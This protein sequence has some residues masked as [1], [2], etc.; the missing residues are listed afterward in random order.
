MW[1]NPTALHSDGTF[2]RLSARGPPHLNDVEDNIL[3]EAVQDTLGYAVV[4]PGSMDKQQILQ[5]FELGGRKWRK[6]ERMNE[7]QPSVYRTPS[8]GSS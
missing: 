8:D 6:K 2:A 1:K 5:V 4:I 3:V 7:K